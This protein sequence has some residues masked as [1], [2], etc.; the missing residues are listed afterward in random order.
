MGPIAR[1][2][3]YLA[4]WVDSHLPQLEG[5]DP[6]STWW[7]GIMQKCCSYVDK[8]LL[9]SAERLLHAVGPEGKEALRQAGEGKSMERLTLG[10]RAQLIELLEIP[11]LAWS[12]RNESPV[13]GPLIGKPG[14]RLLRSISRRRNDFAHDRWSP[15][16]SHAQAIQFLKD[17]RQLCDLPIIRLAIEIEAV[18]D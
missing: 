13:E 9:L 4:V 11:S 6:A 15:E 14:I 12:V 17:S 5:A 2:R 8:L 18:A 7:Y 16:S 10:Q 1:T 3:N